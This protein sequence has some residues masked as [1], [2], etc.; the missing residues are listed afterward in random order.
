MTLKKRYLS[1]AVCGNAIFGVDRSK[2]PIL[3]FAAETSLFIVRFHM[4][5]SNPPVDIDFYSQLQMS[6]FARIVPIPPAK[7]SRAILEFFSTKNPNF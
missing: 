3:A 2:M 5:F 6:F 7:Y 1:D 4:N